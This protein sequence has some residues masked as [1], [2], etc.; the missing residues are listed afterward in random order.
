MM[1][2]LPFMIVLLSSVTLSTLSWFQ[3]INMLLLYLPAAC[4][5]TSSPRSSDTHQSISPLDHNTLASITHSVQSLDQNVDSSY[6][7]GS[8]LLPRQTRRTLRRPPPKPHHHH[9]HHQLTTPT[10]PNH[11]LMRNL[12]PPQ[13]PPVPHRP[14]GLPPSPHPDR[15]SLPPRPSLGPHVAIPAHAAVGAA[16]QPDNDV[17]GHPPRG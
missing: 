15:A 12:V 11:S 4:G 13:R 17:A 8:I 1:T 2:M 3:N 5:G 9:H 10:T 7:Q 16:V 14:L 6:N